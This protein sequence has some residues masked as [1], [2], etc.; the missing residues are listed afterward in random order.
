MLAR[1]GIYFIRFCKCVVNSTT[2]IYY[3]MLLSIA[4]NVTC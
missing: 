4:E 3:Y 2:I 1:L